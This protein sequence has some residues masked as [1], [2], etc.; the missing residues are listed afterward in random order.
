MESVVVIELNGR[1]INTLPSTLL[2]TT[3]ENDKIVKLEDKWDGNDQPEKWGAHVSLRTLLSIMVPL[4][5]VL[6]S[7]PT[8]S[9]RESNAMGEQK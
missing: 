4:T 9:E 6:S 1:L 7:V 8:K 3:Q 5:H 2:T